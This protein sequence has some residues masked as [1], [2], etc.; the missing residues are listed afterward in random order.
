M[1][2]HKLL[3][4]V[5]VVTN[6]PGAGPNGTHLF[7]GG[8]DAIKQMTP[9]K[10]LKVNLFADEAM[11]PEMANPVQMQFDSKG[12]LW[13]AVWPTYPHW[14]PTEEMNDKLLILEDTDGDGKADRCSTFADGLHNP[15]GFEF[16]P[17]GVLIAQC[18]DIMLLKDTN[19]DGKCDRRERVLHGLDTAD[20]HHS[21]NSFAVDP[22][23]AVYFQEGTFH[24]TQVET[25]YGPVQAKCECWRLS[26]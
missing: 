24:H 3:S 9:G 14:K 19:G 13:V 1:K 21:A 8:E 16:V 11:F 22:T 26:V 7:L 23:G 12:R 6:K 25:P 5:P 20:T 4:F 17:G 15:T 10:N 18:P 2:D